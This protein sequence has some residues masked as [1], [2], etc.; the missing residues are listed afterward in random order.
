MVIKSI[1]DDFSCLPYEEADIRRIIGNMNP[2]DKDVDNK[3][4]S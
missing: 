1:K 2:F 4:T 3:K